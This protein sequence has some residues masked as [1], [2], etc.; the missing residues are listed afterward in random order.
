MQCICRSFNASSPFAFPGLRFT[1]PQDS[2]SR[3]PP[4]FC[5]PGLFIIILV[6]VVLVLGFLGFEH[7]DSNLS[8]GL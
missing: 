3:G 6:A 8:A 2:K 4:R 7:A 5:D 1:L